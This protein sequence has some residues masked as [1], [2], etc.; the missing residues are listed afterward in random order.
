MVGGAVLWCYCDSGSH[1]S[2]GSDGGWVVTAFAMD[3]IDDGRGDG[4]LLLWSGNFGH[5]CVDAGHGN[6]S[7]VGGGDNDNDGDE[8][9]ND[10]CGQYDGSNGDG[11]CVGNI[12]IIFS[13]HIAL[14][15]ILN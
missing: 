13:S 4:T 1:G 14:K 5:D 8:V 6:S 9:G 3:S 7:W 10:G 15:Q 11:C 2:H 12:S